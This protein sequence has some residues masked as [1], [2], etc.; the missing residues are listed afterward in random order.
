MTQQ[1]VR[2]VYH[3][4]M[5]KSRLP[6]DLLWVYKW[7]KSTYQRQSTFKA[8]SWSWASVEGPVTFLKTHYVIAELSITYVESPKSSE[9][10]LHPALRIRSWMMLTK[11]IRYCQSG[12]YFGGYDNFVPWACLP[13]SLW[14]SLDDLESIPQA[15]VKGPPG[16]PMELI[17]TWF[18]FLMQD[19]FLLSGLILLPVQGQPGHFQRIGAFEGLSTDG[20]KLRDWISDRHDEDFAEQLSSVSSRRK[21]IILFGART[22]LYGKDRITRKSSIFNRQEIYLI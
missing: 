5:W 20:R 12:N 13:P 17:N 1:A 7:S 4:R 15:N 3:A 21:R 10:R 8:P 18:L 11:S 19:K 6:Q 22:R 14:T 2:D 16:E 9:T